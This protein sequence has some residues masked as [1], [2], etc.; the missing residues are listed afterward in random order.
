MPTQPP[1][2]DRFESL[3]ERRIRDA[4]EHGEFDDLPGSG[5][6]IADLDRPY[7]ASWW[8]R[9]LVVREALMDV[10]SDAGM[11]RTL[12]DAMRE[13]TEPALRARLKPTRLS[14]DDLEAIVRMWRRSRP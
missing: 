5:E 3:A 11:R 8:A 1:S 14:D 6:P 2:P 9:R 10:A 4:M 12:V 13:R 7:D